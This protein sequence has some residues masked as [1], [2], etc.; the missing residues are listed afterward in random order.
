VD[1]DTLDKDMINF[2]SE[3][4]PDSSKFHQAPEWYAMRTYELFISEI[5]HLIFLDYS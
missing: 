2:L 5:F 4:E 3:R 1:V